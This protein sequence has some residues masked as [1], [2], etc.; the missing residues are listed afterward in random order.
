[1]RPEKRIKK[2]VDKKNLPTQ[3]LYLPL[4]MQGSEC[5]NDGK[6]AKVIKA[7]FGEK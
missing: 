3:A 2:L 7:L 4:S 1:M 5:G 6:T